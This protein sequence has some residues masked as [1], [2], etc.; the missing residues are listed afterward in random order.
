MTQKTLVVI[1]ARLAASRLPNK[2]LADIWGK[3]M[4]V[5]V[6]EKASAAKVGPV[7]VA[8]GDQEIFDAVKSF[9]GDAILTD[10]ALPSGTDRAKAATD[11]YD[12]EGTYN[13][14]INVQGDLPTLEPDLVRQV[15][16]PFMNP[17]VDMATLATLIEDPHELAD[18][19]VAKIALSLE[20]KGSIGRALY[21]SRN[22]IPSGIG[23][24]YHHIGIYA[25]TRESLNRYVSLP[26]NSLEARER[27]EQL[28]ALAHG[29]RVDVKIVDSK[30]PFGVDTPADLEKAILVIGESYSC[31]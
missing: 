15:L 8:C 11:I 17:L 14:V 19:N 10:P 28:R 20:G 2:P 29:M 21:F 13:W 22:P 26:V 30:A 24:H 16:D 9:G 1:P 6:W 25:F 4:I 12:P 3:P 27:L 18:P 7:I 31:P 5:H 23:P